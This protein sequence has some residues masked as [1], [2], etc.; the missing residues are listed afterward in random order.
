MRMAI[1]IFRDEGVTPYQRS[2]RRPSST[3]DYGLRKTL[4]STTLENLPLYTASAARE[5]R[6]SEILEH[7]VTPLVQE[8]RT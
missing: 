3:H 8:I 6:A 2:R 4:V 7:K 1:S 5:R